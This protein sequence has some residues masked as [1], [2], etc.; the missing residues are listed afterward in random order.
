MMRIIIPFIVGGYPDFLV[1]IS[2]FA[3]AGKGGG[4]CHQCH[5]FKTV[6]S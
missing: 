4:Y 3:T 2:A 5:H 6:L 1:T